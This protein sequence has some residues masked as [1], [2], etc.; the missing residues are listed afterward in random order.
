MFAFLEGTIDRLAPPRLW[1]ACHGVGYELL[2]SLS[3]SDILRAL[4]SEQPVRV[5]TYLHV[6]EDAHI[7]YGFAT[8]D[9]KALFDLLLSV[10]GVGGVLALTLLSSL[11]PTQIIQ[12]IRSGDEAALERVKGIGKKTAGRLV[13][14]LTDRIGRLQTAAELDTPAAQPLGRAPATRRVREEALA[15]LGSLGF[16]RSAVEKKVDQLL[17]SQPQASLDFVIRAVLKGG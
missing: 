9:E 11:S 3:T 14:E 10:S 5:Y 1:L 13:L 17:E 8:E 7:L 4:P 6:K 16:S 15:A 12:A 2:V